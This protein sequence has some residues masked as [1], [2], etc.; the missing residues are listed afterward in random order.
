M[1]SQAVQ[2]LMIGSGEYTTGYVPSAVAESDKG[3]GVVGI[4]LFHLRSRRKVGGISL[5]GTNGSKFPA[6]RAHFDTNIKAKYSDDMDCSVNTFP[7]DG[8]TDPQAYI[9]ALDS[10]PKGSAV[11]V[12]T[13]DDTHFAITLAA[14]KRGLHVLTTKPLVKTLEEHQELLAAAT[15]NNVLVMCEVHKRFDPIYMDARDRIKGLGDFSYFSSYMS[16][17]KT[18]LE[19]FRAWAGKSSDISY[20]KCR[21]EDVNLDLD[22][23]RVLHKHITRTC[24]TTQ[25]IQ[26]QTRTTLCNRTYIFAIYI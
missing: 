23:S 6:I 25:C 22:R 24:S 1:A 17:P 2:C 7:A 18:Q 16:Q 14:V 3:A 9:A 12:F 8:V 15:E 19:T 4:T 21:T 26:Y 13:P 5:C 20:C 10:M 11:T